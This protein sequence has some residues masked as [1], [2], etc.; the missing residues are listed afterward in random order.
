MKRSRWVDVALWVPALFLAYVFLR[1][2]TAKFSDASGW[3]R[4]FQVWHFPVWFRM[5]IGA[6]ETTAALMLL[7]RRTASIGA[8]IIAIVML[9]GMATH[10]YWGQL[11][12]IRSE[13]LPLTLSLIVMV[14]RMRDI[15]VP[16]QWH[17]WFSRARAQ[18]S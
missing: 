15:M 16:R 18:P 7:T 1:Q 2:G 9:G 12:Q 3:A 10:V 17:G 5:L 8:G 14:A 6:L 4:A 13:A 11:A